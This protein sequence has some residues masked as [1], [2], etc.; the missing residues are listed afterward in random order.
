MNKSAGESFAASV[1]AKH[2]PVHGSGRITRKVSD[3][4]ADMDYHAVAPPEYRAGGD[5]KRENLCQQDSQRVNMT[6]TGTSSSRQL[7]TAGASSKRLVAT[8]E[9]SSEKRVHLHPNID[10]EKY[11]R[12]LDEPA[13]NLKSAERGGARILQSSIEHY[14]CQVFVPD[15]VKILPIFKISLTLRSGAN[16]RATAYGLFLRLQ[17]IGD[18]SRFSKH[19]RFDTICAT[20]GDNIDRSRKTHAICNSCMTGIRFKNYVAGRSSSK[21]DQDLSSHVLR[22]YIACW[23]L[24]SRSIQ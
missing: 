2:K 18:E 1:N 9:L 10:G 7:E 21:I 23:S 8:D 14:M 24:K 17:K 16:S 6:T 4:N 20:T 13:K 19:T 12:K 22:F 5:S 15:L 11:I 3:K